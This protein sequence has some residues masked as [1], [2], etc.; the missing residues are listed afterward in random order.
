MNKFFGIFLTPLSLIYYLL[1]II[2]FNFTK[3][4]YSKNKVICVGN[5]SMGGTGKTPICIY[6]HKLLKENGIDTVFMLRG[7]GKNI[8]NTIIANGNKKYSTIGDEAMLY[9][10]LSNTYVGSNRVNSLKQIE[11]REEK[12]VV[13]ISDDGFQNNS[14]NKD[15]NICVVDGERYFGNGFVFP[16]GSLRE[17]VKSLSKFDCIILN[18]GNDVSLLAKYNKNVFKASQN[19]SYTDK[20]EKDVVLVS[21]IGNNKKFF[22]SFTV[23]N[24]NNVV[25][26]FEFIDHHDYSNKEILEIL[27]FADKNNC[28]IVTTR[29][30]YVKI[31]NKYKSKFIVQDLE[32]FI[33]N[34][35]LL[36]EIINEKICKIH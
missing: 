14:F 36:L 33:E 5:I 9:Q 11:R 28:D 7:Y 24:N 22:K 27:Y 29:K 18:N 23:N 31:P 3:K 20:L 15:F 32:I 10:N 1:H 8:K 34:K 19:Y 4:Y 30:D 16:A 26:H 12:S 13:V 21:G 35:D 6:I 17:K 2:K 25:K